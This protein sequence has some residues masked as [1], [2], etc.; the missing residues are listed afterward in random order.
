MI[1]PYSNR[2]QPNH[3][4]D[5]RDGIM[6]VDRQTFARL[7]SR[8]VHTIRL[9]C[10]VVEYQQGKAMY[11]AFKCEEILAMIPQRAPT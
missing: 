4:V 2:T 7:V 1:D 10:P 9:R 3:I 5:Y 6:L 11:D 8:S